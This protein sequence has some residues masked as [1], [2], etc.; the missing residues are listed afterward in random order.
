MANIAHFAGGS[1]STE[2]AYMK[3]WL[4]QFKAIIEDTLYGGS[5]KT[6]GK[7]PFTSIINPF[8]FQEVQN[9]LEDG[10]SLMT[11]FGHAASG[12][13]FSRK[14]L[15]NQLIGIIKENTH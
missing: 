8:E 2:Q 7:D 15:M 6:F 12:Y 3:G 11:F 1:D 9:Y 13:G 5:V 4:N 14:I 10:I